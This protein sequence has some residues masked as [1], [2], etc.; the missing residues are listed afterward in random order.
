MGKTPEPG[1]ET[2]KQS[3]TVEDLEFYEYWNAEVQSGGKFF[4]RYNNLNNYLTYV[5]GDNLDVYVLI[6]SGGANEPVVQKYPIFISTG[7]STKIEV[8][9][10]NGVKKFYYIAKNET[11]LLEDTDIAARIEEMKNSWEKKFVTSFE[12]AT[13]QMPKPYMDLAESA[14]AFTVNSLNM[15]RTVQFSGI[16][17]KNIRN[18]QQFFFLENAHLQLKSLDE[19]IYP[20]IVLA[21]ISA[22]DTLRVLHSWISTLNELGNMG[23]RIV[24]SVIQLENVQSPMLFQLLKELLRNPLFEGKLIDL[25]DNIEQIAELTWKNSIGSDGLKSVRW[26][27]H[28]RGIFQ[29]EPSTANGESSLE[30]LSLLEDM[31][32]VMETLNKACKVSDDEKWIKRAAETESARSAH[33]DTENLVYGDLVNKTF[34][35]GLTSYAP[36][37]LSL[38]KPDSVELTQSLEKLLQDSLYTSTGLQLSEEHGASVSYNFLLLRSLERYKDLAGPS[39]EA[40]LHRYSHL[41]NSLIAAIARSQRSQKTFY[42]RFDKD[43]K[44]LGPR[45]DLDGALVLPIMTELVI[46]TDE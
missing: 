33:W 44:P 19:Q 16:Y 18:S 46:K 5:Y 40:A 6:E 22:Q 2:D 35:T 25:R 41:K 43:M 45:G 9:L 39:Q 11:T 31:C 14:L 29:L 27:G 21:R 1:N 38:L 15:N 23:N 32:K 8:L 12:Q 17:D 20:L 26:L 7:D 37:I 30:L 34:K 4:F 28:S 3:I 36:L 42:E 24:N 10:E 13:Q